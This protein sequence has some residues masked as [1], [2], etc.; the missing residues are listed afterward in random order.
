MARGLFTFRK[1]EE[2]KVQFLLDGS[3]LVIGNWTNDTQGGYKN[4]MNKE[5]KQQK[6]SPGILLCF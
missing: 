6:P 4:K 5:H 2:F 3:V 1:E